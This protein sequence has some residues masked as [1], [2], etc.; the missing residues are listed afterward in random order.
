MTTGSV[1]AE[2]SPAD[3]RG[4]HYD[5]VTIGL[6][7]LTAVLALSLF[8][9]AMWWSYAP[10]AIR[11]R[12]ELEDIHVALG[13]LL[14]AVVLRRL[15]WRSTAGRRLPAAATG[16]QQR[17]AALVHGLLYLLLVVQVGLGLVLR[18]LQGAELSFFGWFT[19][20][21][22]LAKD[23]GAAEIVETLHNW[24]G[25][26]LVL[27]AGGH[28]AAALLHRFWMGDGVLQ[29]MLPGRER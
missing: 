5:G 16:L 25:W 20:P 23:R 22:L 18:G 13:M 1:V 7:W 17:L 2:S 28:A 12:F 10:R 29:R 24:S 19:L 3:G 27:L 9:T 26:A 8:A 21:A 15:L 11:F 4:K 14:A 6:H